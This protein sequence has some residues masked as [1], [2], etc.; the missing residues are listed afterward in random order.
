LHWFY[1]QQSVAQTADEASQKNLDSVETHV[2]KAEGHQLEA[3]C[4]EVPNIEDE[5]PMTEVCIY[6]CAIVSRAIE[7]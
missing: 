7:W 6:N 4:T 1:P 3:K 5:K 2:E